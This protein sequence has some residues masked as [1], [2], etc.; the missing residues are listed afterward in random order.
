VSTNAAAR[1]AGDLL[2]EIADRCDP[3]WNDPARSL[4]V[5]ALPLALLAL[6]LREGWIGASRDFWVPLLWGL[7]VPIWNTRRGAS[8]PWTLT[9]YQGR[10][11]FPPSMA[12]VHAGLWCVAVNVTSHLGVAMLVFI[13]AFL[14]FDALMLHFGILRVYALPKSVH[15][16]GSLATL[17][18]FGLV[19][20]F[21]VACG[22]ALAHGKGSDSLPSI[23]GFAALMVIPAQA[24]VTAFG[25]TRAPAERL[26]AE[27]VAI[28]GGGFSGLYTAKWLIEMGCEPTV[29]E[30]SD[31]IGGVWRYDHDQPG[32][33]FEQTRATSSLHFMHA[34]DFPFPEGT[35]DFPSHEQLLAY[36]ESYADEFKLR[37]HVQLKSRVESVARRGGSWQVE[38]EG[39]GK[40]RETRSFDAVVV[41]SGPQGRPRICEKEHPLY[42]RFQGEITHGR[43][44][45]RP[46]DF[47]PGERVLVV[48]AGESAADIVSECVD[49][50]LT[51]DWSTRRGQWFADRNIGPHAADHFT[52]I[53][54]RSLF[55]LFLNVEYLIRRF[56]IAT[57]INLAWGK[58]GHGVRGWWP[59]VPYL[60][61]FLNKS[62]DGILEVYRGRVK[63]HSG[64]EA[65]N[66]KSVRFRG[67]E[68]PVQY[69]RII[70]ATGYVPNWPFLEQQPK[71]LY[72]KVFHPEDPTLSFVGLARPVLGSITGT[73]EVQARWIA[74]VLSGT[75]TLPC[76]SRRELALWF[77]QRDHP[78][79]FLDSSPLGV[80][81]DHDI[82][83]SKLAAECG[84]HVP[85][86]KLL[87]TNMRGLRAVLRSPW[88]AFK[89]EL[90]HP[91]PKR[92]QAAVENIEREMPC[93]THPANLIVGLFWLAIP[94]LALA[95]GLAFWHCPAWAVCAWL[96]GLIAAAAAFFRLTEL[97]ARAKAR[98]AVPG[99][100]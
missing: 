36:L 24:I 79:R 54:V 42:S 97:R 49:A 40:R 1:P 20:W 65:V 4:L 71:R 82:Y 81:C 87:F 25:L 22:F 94:S 69:D 12:L 90:N 78:R 85:W 67:E 56:I 73:A 63:A 84:L 33:V 62:R 61:Q 34:A 64:V 59:E 15:E 77:D 35:P 92:R 21:V 58:G 9:D 27:R 91:D 10:E 68:E 98:A 52:A 74:Y 51:V 5:Y 18:G 3:T 26:K 11:R 29:F 80:L 89:F 6:C 13:G 23:L 86:W 8:S 100:S 72:G 46:E 50:G 2:A 19:W 70:L 31:D 37:E 57:Y 47:A 60:H 39:P 28:I 16:R 44:Y 45:K 83:T 7:T 38:V 76:A 53:G 32:G 41:C 48:G 93:R 75:T 43:D 88:V 99:S 55:G 30:A 96:A 17:A 66:G 14:V 95:L